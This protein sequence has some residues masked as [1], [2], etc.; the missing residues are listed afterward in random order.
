[1]NRFL[2]IGFATLAM[3]LSSATSN[4]TVTAID[5]TG[6][7]L[8]SVTVNG[9]QVSF[10]SLIVGEVTEFAGASAAVLLVGDNNPLPAGAARADLLGDN[11][12]DTGV[13]NP[14]RSAT[15]VTYV[16]D[17][18]VRNQAGTDIFFL[19]FDSNASDPLD[20]MI[21][22]VTMSV[23]R[24]PQVASG[25]PT[26]VYSRTAGTVANIGQL[27]NDPFSKTS[28]TTQNVFAYS[29]DLSD[30]G[31]LDFASINSIQWGSGASGDTI[32]PVLIAAVP[33]IPEPATALLGVMGLVGFAARRRRV[34]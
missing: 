10:D 12:I 21:N 30:F 2:S 26:D 31:V 13:I 17:A 33:S 5:N 14:A 20:V 16:F 32:D 19:E 22:G 1:M 4:A 27:L 29:I 28:D 3:V 25:I 7:V 6:A 8:N 15:A 24:G 23:A 9:V 11:L 34:A 18:P